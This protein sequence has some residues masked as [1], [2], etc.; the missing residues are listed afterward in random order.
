MLSKI[1][2]NNCKNMILARKYKYIKEED[3]IMLFS[4]NN[5]SFIC[6]FL[7]MFDKL[8]VSNVKNIINTLNNK[9]LNHAI[10]IYKTDTTSYAKKIINNIKK[11]FV[12]ETFFEKNLLYDITKHRLVPKHIELSNEESKKFIKDYGKKF[13]VILKTDPICKYYNFKKGNIIKIIRNNNYIIY[14]IVK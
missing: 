6:L 9:N 13:P 7:I 5:K 8:D 1:I 2:Q 10:I 14:R 11:E 4:K 12:I 3:N